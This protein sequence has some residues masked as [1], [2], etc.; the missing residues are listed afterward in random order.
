VI[1][2]PPSGLILGKTSAL[3]HVTGPLQIFVDAVEVD[4]SGSFFLRFV[5][6]GAGND[7]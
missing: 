5:G 4:Y 7:A 1:V 6:V 2:P 3:W